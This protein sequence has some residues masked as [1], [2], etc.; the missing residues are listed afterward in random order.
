M[1]LRYVIE[2]FGCIVMVGVA[3][4]GMAQSNAINPA[5]QAADKFRFVILADPQ[6]SAR[7]NTGKVS[8]NAQETT[9][10]AA[11]EVNQM[12]PKPAFVL[13]LGDLV[14]VFEPNS[15]ANFK[16]LCRL[17][18]GP[19]VVM[20]GNHEPLPPYEGYRQL[21]QELSGVSS[22]FYSFNAGKWH[23]IITPCNLQGNSPAE[24]R[25]EKEMLTWL[26]ADLSANQHRPTVFFNHLH[27]MPQG[28]SQTEFYQQPLPLRRKMLELMCRYGNVKYYFNGHVH[29]GIQTSAK[30]AWQYR[31]IRFFSVPTIIQPRP[32]GEEYPA[33]RAGVDRGGYY[34]VVDVEGDR[35][36]LRG[37]LSGVEQ[38]YV[39]P[40]S[41][42]KPFNDQ[43]YPL[44][45]S[46]LPQLP[47][48]EKLEN[49]DFSRGLGG[50]RLPERYQRDADPFFIARAERDG[51]RLAVKTPVDSI[52]AD[53]EYMQLA[54]I[55]AL[56]KRAAPVLSGRYQ[57][58][59]KPLAGGGYLMATLMGAD[60]VKGLMFFRW[61]QQE[62]MSNYLPRC[63]GYQQSGHQVSWE[64]FQ[65]LGKKKQAM[66]WSLPD[67]TGT[68]H[69]FHLNLKEL[70]DKSHEP[71]AFDALGITRLEVAI[72]VWNQNNVPAMSSE[73]RFANLALN[74]DS[75]ATTVDQA[76]LASD[77]SVFTCRF[78]QG[79]TDQLRKL[80]MQKDSD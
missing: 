69:Q 22:P 48:R 77:A 12:S 51:V 17:F 73:A 20:H 19:N 57:L 14:N 34:L 8:V 60:Q 80:K 61:S 56:P 49:G 1:K 62:E 5:P 37:R 29:N 38:E 46:T 33:Y 27:F 41:I 50:W 2:R 30:T 79:V 72:G 13:W 31:G 74:F 23:F 42:F 6:V 55:V 9:A 58:M 71:G 11:G 15:I 39:F 76:P 68:W 59:A 32:Y 36:S 4:T 67:S 65:E 70:Y 63:T 45:F 78:G 54:Q 21:Q 18:N 3:T 53:D 26:E 52:W 16:R 43:D 25:M 35:L 66:F 40:E 24:I 10:Q 28:L 44:W 64:Y 47:A 75:T 7:N